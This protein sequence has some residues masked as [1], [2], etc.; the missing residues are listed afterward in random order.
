MKQGLRNVLSGDGS[1]RYCCP[2]F[3]ACDLHGPQPVGIRL[4]GISLATSSVALAAVTISEHD[5]FRPSGAELGGA[6][7]KFS[8]N[9][10]GSKSS[11][12]A[13]F[14]GGCATADGLQ[15]IEG[16]FSGHW[17]GSGGGSSPLDEP[18]ISGINDSPGDLTHLQL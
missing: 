2:T 8:L 14:N 3:L 16:E 7:V 10:V 6:F 5:A 15:L 17:F 18:T 4:P 12:Q 11:H 13:V 9:R 1:A